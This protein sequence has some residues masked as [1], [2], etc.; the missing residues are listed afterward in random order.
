MP[1]HRRVTPSIRFAGTH[2]YTRVERGTV[3]VKMCL[4]KNTTQCPRPGPEPRPLDPELSAL[5][6]R[7]PRLPNSGIT[8]LLRKHLCLKYFGK[9][10]TFTLNQKLWWMSFTTSQHMHVSGPIQIY[11]SNKARRSVLWEVYVFFYQQN[12][13][14]KQKL[15]SISWQF[16]NVTLAY[17]TDSWVSR[18]HKTLR[19]LEILTKQIQNRSQRFRMHFNSA[20]SPWRKLFYHCG[21]GVYFAM[22]MWLNKHFSVVI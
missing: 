10:Y 18:S 16:A 8:N 19:W 13:H 11:K 3:R 15:L 21:N 9:Y 2:F 22:A 14:R 4:P 5:T 17:V 7:P 20:F 1:V 12:K 6:M